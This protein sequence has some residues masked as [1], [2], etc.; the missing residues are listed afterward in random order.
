MKALVIKDFIVLKKAS[1]MFPVMIMIFA[2]SNCSEY[3]IV[4]LFAASAYAS[5]T[6]AYDEEYGWNN[7]AFML[8]YSKFELV[9]SKY[10]LNYILIL[11]VAGIAQLLGVT[12]NLLSQQ[13][14]ITYI[15]FDKFILEVSVVLI[16]TSISIWA[17]FKYGCQKGKLIEILFI[18]ISICFSSIFDREP[19]IQYMQYLGGGYSL[20][21]IIVFVLA[22]ICNLISIK[23]SIGIEKE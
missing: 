23:C 15:G 5:S 16:A 7:Y 17:Q 8:P 9:V 22:I 19:I 14:V 4:W 2:A 10:I 20:L 3:G 6:M 13:E 11:I 18:G 21:A 12:F 1:K